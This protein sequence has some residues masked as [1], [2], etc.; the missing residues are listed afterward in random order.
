MGYNYNEGVIM[1]RLLI[2]KLR[3]WKREENRKPLL[4]RGARQVGKTYLVREFAKNEFDNFI[5]VNFEYERNIC[6]I[7]NENLDPNFL[8]RYLSARFRTKITQNTLIFFDEIQECPNALVLMRYFYEK[9]KDVFLIGAGS[10][11]EFAIEKVGLPVGRIRSL[12]LYPLNFKEFLI[13]K[14]YEQYI[15]LLKENILNGRISEPIHKDLLMFLSEYL[16][17]GGMPEV[18]N[19]YINNPDDFETILR[20][21]EDII[22]GYRDDFPKYSKKSKIRYIDIVYANTLLYIGKK[23]VYSNISREVKSREIKEALLLLEKAGVFYRVF[24]TSANGLPLGA[25]KNE[26]KFKVI[27]IDIGLMQSILGSDR[28]EWMKDIEQNFMLKGM[29]VENF[30]GAELIS[31]ENP[32]K[33]PELYYW[34]REKIIIENNQRKKKK[35][36][37]EV[38]YLINLNN[39]IIPLEVKSGKKKYSGSLKIFL[40]EKKSDFGIILSTNNLEVYK[41]KSIINLPVYSVFLLNE[42]Y[43]TLIKLVKH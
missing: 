9:R 39:R 32:Y 31:Y 25:E 27:F 11:L 34:N 4:I 21:T 19:S 22:N 36:N 43:E 1:Y 41:N 8:L 42:L 23:Y 3:Q 26:K 40:Q 14:G 2:E 10:L 29:I 12:Y 7:L 24:H 18:V 5:E 33:K 20:I 16:T 28:S 30:V 38:D 17:I 35:T 6:P 37:A 15:D 13:N